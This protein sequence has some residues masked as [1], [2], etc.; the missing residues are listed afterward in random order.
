MT[1]AELKKLF[2]EQPALFKEVLGHIATTEEGKELL[3]NYAKTQTDK[4]IGDKTSE[5]YNGIDKDVKD[6]LGVDKPTDKKT[7]EFVKELVTELKDLRAKKGEG[8][9][10]EGKDGARV[11][12]LET[13]L[14]AIKDQNW[15]GKYNSLVSETAVKIEGF[16][17]KIKELE[18]GNTSSL[19]NVELAT[20]LS[21]LKFNPN[22]PKEA[23][24][25]MTT[26][27]KDKIT[28]TAK[29]VDGKV[30]YYKEDGTPYLNEL[31]KPITAEEIFKTELKTIISGTN[32]GGG[33]ADTTEKGKI[34]T[35]GEGDNA[36]KKVALDPSKFNTK[37]AFANHIEEVLL[38]NGV[39]KNSKEWHGIVQEA[40]TEYGVDKMD[41]T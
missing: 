33:G 11:A 27:V 18:T 28:K 22:I 21:T 2:G 16:T 1:L 34:V 39:E 35:V 12:E 9:G 3:N 4:A 26:V 40:R 37:L 14:K 6:I 7:Y 20:G 23:I 41:R 10:D 17:T 25:A 31:Y 29:V 30:V 38:E 36:K 13:Q 15:E 24:D 5:I 19:V 32:V 8:K